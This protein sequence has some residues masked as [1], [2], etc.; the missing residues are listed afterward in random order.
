M[1][2]SFYT[3][4]LVANLGGA[5][6]AWIIG[7]IVASGLYY[8]SMRQVVRPAAAAAVQSVTRPRA[9][10]GRARLTTL[11]AADRARGPAVLAG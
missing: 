1:F 7:L 3:G 4:P 9:P 10:C 8:L 2:T 5:D 11:T 6:V